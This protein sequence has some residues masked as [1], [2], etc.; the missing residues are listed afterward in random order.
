MTTTAA[1]LLLAD[2]SRPRSQQ[3]EIGMSDLGSCRRRVGYKLAGTKPVNEV[4]SVQAV[5]GSA[6]H[7]MIADV[8]A[9]VAKPG[10]LVEHEVT[11]AGIVGHLDRYEA[12]RQT[13]CDTKTT[14]SRWLEHIKL[15]G[16]DH[17]HIWQVSCYAAALINEGTPVRAVQI[18]YIARDTGEEF[19]W[20]KPFDPQDVR[21]ALQW[22]KV[23]RETPLDMLPREYD[24]ESV[25][26]RGCPFGG[27]DGGICWE[28]HVAGRD[29]RSVL[30]VTDDDAQRYAE[31]LWQ[32]R[33]DAKDAREREA[34]AKG[35]LDAIRMEGEV[36]QVG[37]KWFLRWGASGLRFVSGPREIE[38]SA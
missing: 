19:V 1:L 25:F 20:S 15:H 14:S 24:P 36:V 33:Q 3:R 34:E 18:D 38:V 6:I 22:L 7:D 27:P 13:V 23:V 17:Q 5:M 32:A 30:V 21:D 11:F 10:D 16:P 12:D 8:L 35:A 9:Q 2:R 4:G 28:G 31:Q 26:C 29:K 37:E